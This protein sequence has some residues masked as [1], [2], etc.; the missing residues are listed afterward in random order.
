MKDA[1]RHSKQRDAAGYKNIKRDADIEHIDDLTQLVHALELEVGTFRDMTALIRNQ[2]YSIISFV[3][4]TVIVRNN[5][6]RRQFLKMLPI[7]ETDMTEL[8]LVRYERRST[9]S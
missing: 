8:D 6:H 4:K 7:L 9:G 3:L 2:L 1:T 5:R